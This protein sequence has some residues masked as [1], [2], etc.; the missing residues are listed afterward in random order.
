MKIVTAAEMREID[1]LTTER[2]GV[3]SLKLMENAGTAVAEFAQKHFDFTSACVVCGKGNN[4]GDGFVAARKLKEAG[5][6]VSVIVL[7]GSAK[8]LRGDAAE[9]FKR[10]K[11]KPQWVGKEADFKAAAVH[12]ALQA[13]LIVDAILGTGFKPPL[14]GIAGK[15]IAVINELSAT[16]LAVDLP[17]G[18]DADEWWGSD[19]HCKASA[20]VTFTAPK[21]AHAFAPMTRGPMVVAP[22]GTPGEAVQSS[23]GLEW[24]G[25]FRKQFTVDRFLD[26]NK[27]EF[28]HVFV[29]GGSVGKAGAPS[30]TSAAVLKVGAG[31]VT[32]WVPASILPTV[33][34]FC[35]E[36]MTGRLAETSEG[37][38]ARKAIDPLSTQKNRQRFVMA[39]GPGVS[40]NAETVTYIKRLVATCDVPM[41][42]DAD[43]L[44]AFAGCAELLDGSKRPLVLTPHPGEMCRLTGLSIKEVVDKPLK[45]ARDFATRHHVHVVLKMWRTIIA[46]PDGRARVNTTGNPGLA[47]GGSGDVLTG[48]IA[49]MVAQ[50]R[51][52]NVDVGDAACRAVDLH[53]LCADIAVSEGDERTL[54]ASDI[55]R[56]LPR[57]IRF[58][59]KRQKLEWL[60]GFPQGT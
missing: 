2:Y 28:G 1:R 8:E 54:V 7:A 52:I 13:E 36:V 3:P 34:Q 19:G 57:A 30:M 53:G 40:T 56:Y 6:K 48:L 39:V 42:L 35:P 14:K 18:Y 58:L 55:I 49:G 11:F 31:L 27:G 20:V 26:A 32:A 51:A 23:L 45:V 33:A 5:K 16:V 17:S 41:V 60:R 50:G 44:N 22:I 37:T 46:H 24:A 25:S 21:Q 59:R 10:L 47:K 15:A 9:M 43:G 4:G 38:I 12:K 29:V